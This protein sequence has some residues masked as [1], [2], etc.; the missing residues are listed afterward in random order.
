MNARDRESV[1]SIP[2]PV[3]SVNSLP[4]LRDSTGKS[5]DGSAAVE[6]ESLTHPVDR[7]AA[8]TDD[9]GRGLLHSASSVNVVMNVT[10]SVKS[11]L[12]RPSCV[13]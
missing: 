8:V 12:T 10:E 6:S 13:N 3:S 4:C 5:R 9:S 7:N 2:N 11:E 1:S